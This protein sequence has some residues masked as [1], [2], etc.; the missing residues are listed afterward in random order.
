[1]KYD[2]EIEHKKKSEKSKMQWKEKVFI[3]GAVWGHQ[4]FL[5]VLTYLFISLFVYAAAGGCEDG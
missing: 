5:C 4:I 3:I 2:M 1:M